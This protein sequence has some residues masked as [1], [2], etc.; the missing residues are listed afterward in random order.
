MGEWPM[1]L[2]AAALVS[3]FYLPRFARSEARLA[4]HEDARVESLRLAVESGAE[5]AEDLA[6]AFRIAHPESR[7]LP[8]VEY[9]AGM[10]VTVRARNGVFPG[11][12]ALSRAWVAL[13][14]A[15]Q[16]GFDAVRVDA[17]Q[18]EAASLLI[19]RE[20]FREG[21]ERLSELRRRT[22][23]PEST[24]ELARAL[25]RRAAA[26]PDRQA[27]LD[28][29]AALLAEFV[30]EAPPD[31]RLQGFL[32]QARILG[33]LGRHEEVLPTLVRELAGT[34][35]PAD[36][37]R[38]Q[39]ER[40]R[41]LARLNRPAEA[42]AAL[43]EAERLVERP[44]EKAVARLLQ[45][46]LFARSGN[47]ECLEL[48]RRV[49]ADG[50]PYAPVA[51]LIQGL[52]ELGSRRD[53]ALAALAL[54]LTELRRPRI[55]DEAGFDLDWLE[56]SLR[57]AWEGESAP[58]R[59]D[60]FAALLA[61]RHRLHPGRP[62]ILLDEARLRLRARQ[63]G[64]AA[65]R[66]L[67]AADLLEGDDRARAVHD[68]ALACTEGGLHARA[69]EIFRLLTDLDPRRHA[70]GLYEQGVALRRAS[71]PQEGLQ[72]L[73][74]Y[75]RRTDG[76]GVRAGAAV[77]ARGGILEDLGRTEEA[78]KEY[79]RLLRAREVDSDPTRPEWAA[80]LLRK[81]TLLLDLRRT[82]DARPAIDEY[83]ERYG[84]AG[85]TGVVR[86]ADLA[87]RAAQREARWAD[88][89]AALARLRAA[90]ERLAPEERP[91]FASL[92]RDADFL[93][94]DFR[95]GL[96]DAEGALHAYAE[97]YRK[98][99]ASDERLW[100]LLGRGRALARLGRLE[101][102]RRDYANGRVLLEERA[103]HFASMLGGRGRDYWAAELDLLA[104]EIR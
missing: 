61:E 24:I 22:K 56:S 68:A 20:R 32:T 11:V 41:A 64:A 6:R 62:G 48:C 45:A 65:D 42:F 21:I 80:A 46:E 79:E 54:G 35:R 23:D 87:A 2:A 1:A 50:G 38:L 31:R 4:P 28:E 37:G 94:G 103:E 81:A 18:R 29:S 66:F 83:L 102:A 26:E 76:R 16:A 82:G 72:A 59:L 36:R 44:E 53:A 9:L 75:L 51:R 39:L 5:D 25:G 13:S 60:R 43:D 91:A 73:D 71:R 70:E 74:A 77:L 78:L 8:E 84:D 27:L 7:H 10:A 34:T 49:I 96:G 101:E 47:P 67:A 15:R 57:S 93:V 85:G 12:P 14:S 92:V 89:L 52:H 40:G 100:G 86:A 99:I 95:L 104:R 17:A 97:A 88:G 19:E 3:L 90:F 69:A 33:D 58:E 30:R 55:L 63:P 98:H